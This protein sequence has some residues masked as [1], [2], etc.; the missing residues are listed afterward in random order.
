VIQS[1]S[2]A[3]HAGKEAI[4]L[5][6]LLVARWWISDPAFTCVVADTGCGGPSPCD[7][8]AFAN[9]V[10]RPSKY[11]TCMQHVQVSM[12]KYHDF[13]T[14]HNV[15]RVLQGARKAAVCD[16]A[17]CPMVTHCGRCHSLTLSSKRSTM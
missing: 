2:V 4:G 1:A 5:Q 14:V 16:L 15:L 6:K 3:V 8:S 10:I 12:H 13:K 7:S 9:S 17:F 11:A